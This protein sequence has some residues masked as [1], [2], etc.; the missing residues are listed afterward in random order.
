MNHISFNIQVTPE[1]AALI[2]Q[3]TA[4]VSGDTKATSK[5]EPKAEAKAESKA[6]AKAESKTSAKIPMS[7]VREAVKAAKEDH[8]DDFCKEVLTANGAKGT[9]LGRMISSLDGEAYAAVIEQLQ[10][11][12][13]GEAGKPEESDDDLDTDDLDTDGLDTDDDL[14][15]DLDAEEDDSEDIE[16]EAVKLAVRSYAKEAGREK[17]RTLMNNNGAATLA[18]ID[19]CT[20]EQL[21]AMF[22]VATA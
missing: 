4:L 3:M 8:G 13:Q 11:G 17:A 10:A 2:E 18:A 7:D 5:P 9:A 6:K 12:P 14:G 22:K 15:D 1:N 19:K 16:P 20:Q 21:K